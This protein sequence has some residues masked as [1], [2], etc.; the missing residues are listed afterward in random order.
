[1]TQFSEADASE[2]MLGS[3]TF[4]MALSGTFERLVSPRI[5]D[6]NDRAPQRRVIAGL[7][8]AGLAAAL[9][10]PFAS[11]G[12]FGPRGVVL[13]AIIAGACLALAGLLASSGRLT[14]VL[15]LAIAAASALVGAL[16]LAGGGVSSPLL[17]L[18]LLAPIEA[19]IAGRRHLAALAVGVSCL[20]LSAV[21]TAQW[22]GLAATATFGFDG[23]L[24]AGLG[25]VYGGLQT[26]RLWRAREK[27]NALRGLEGTE[28]LLIEN[29]LTEAVLRF[30]PDG[31]LL[32]ASLAASGL[33]ET[34]ARPLSD[35]A[36]FQA[37][38]ITD[39]V[40][41]LKAFGD[42][43]GGADALAIE[44][45]VQ[46]AA[47]AT[48]H[49]RDV[50]L[51]M[52]AVR[53][54]SGR[55][56][57]I[58]AI[59]RDVT[60]ERALT[61]EL[62]LALSAAEQGSDAK[63]HFLAAV[64]HELRTPLNA[65]IGFSDVLHQE[66][67]GGFEDPRQREYVGLIRQSGEH[68]LSV[69]NGLLDISKIEAGRYE[70]E[71]ERFDVAKALVSAAALIRPQA[72]RKGLVLDVALG[73]H[74]PEVVADRHACHQ[75]LLNL[76]A[77]AVKFTDHGGVT[78][79]ADARG[80]MLVLSVA[81][82]GIGIA[83]KDLPRLG[84]PFTQLSQ[85]IARRYQGTGLGLSLVKGLA[86]LHHGSMEIASELGRGTTVTVRIPLDGMAA[87]ADIESSRNKIVALT[88][89]CKETD[90]PSRQ[91]RPSRRTA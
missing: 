39:R 20:A 80:G 22:L 74:L 64:S 68:L 75:I 31:S 71:V 47:S 11:L 41:Y 37:I 54:T 49:F 17:F 30:S 62:T 3:S 14:L 78:L 38:H 91:D 84:Q 29:G 40:R 67:F 1:M 15:S 9:A 42:L 61:A 72:E 90:S 45:K 16:A 73:P 52:M 50:S 70:L 82:T 12:D 48:Q 18:L 76:L 25:L 89:A 88:D 60:S 81:D 19:T 51:R 85:G 8:A 87:I 53:D 6:P 4:A 23:T 79:R 46:S 66:L 59:A 27:T 69:V 32:T 36:I 21:A 57:A 43:R 44:V 65:I 35:K 77:N 83:Q 5:L 13:P 86:V 28:A 24:T 7:V 55:L 58:L 56:H 2:S 34:S 63:S 26:L 33:F 10:L